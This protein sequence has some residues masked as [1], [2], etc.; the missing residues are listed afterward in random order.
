[1]HAF[2]PAM[3]AGVTPPQR[4][5]P[6][7]MPVLG[8]LRGWGGEGVLE[9]LS[10]VGG[11]TAL[12]YYI[13]HMRQANTPAQLPLARRRRNGA[14][15]MASRAIINIPAPRIFD[16][17]MMALPHFPPTR[18]APAVRPRAGHR[19]WQL[20][21]TSSIEYHARAR[22]FSLFRWMCTHA[23]LRLHQFQF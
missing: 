2:S 8:G 6:G 7:L 14:L 15:Q 23:Q 16:G 5:M 9:G 12:L 20:D 11:S 21:T 19:N 18:W 13:I 3:R 1:M 22:T 17:I 4:Q 10:D